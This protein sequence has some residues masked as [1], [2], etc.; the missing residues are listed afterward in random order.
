MNNEQDKYND[1]DT[2]ENFSNG[3]SK[4]RRRRAAKR[5]GITSA[6]HSSSKPNKWIKENTSPKT[7]AELNTAD[8][9]GSEIAE[10][11]NTVMEDNPQAVA[12]DAS[13]SNKK[14]NKGKKSPLKTFLTVL[15]SIIGV[16]VIVM[17]IFAISTYLNAD[18]DDDWSI[19][20]E[21]PIDKITEVF[22]PKLPDRTQFVIMCTDEDGTRTDTIMVG[23]YNS[24]TQGISLLSVPRDTI[25]SV[26]AAN[27]QTMREEFPEPGQRT[28]KINAV[29]HY[30]GNDLGPE[31]LVD[32][33]NS[34]LGTDIQYYVRINFDAFHYLIDSIGGIEFDVPQDMDYDDPTQDL[35]IHLKAGL[36]TLDGDKAEQL[37][38][39][40]KDNYGGGY[41][42]GDLGRIEMQQNFMKVLITKLASVD[43]IKSNPK[44]YITAFIK[45]VKTNAGVSDAVKYASALNKID[46]NKIDTYTLPGYIDY[47]AGISGYSPDKEQV[48]ELIYNICEKP[49]DEIVAEQ[50][51]ELTSEGEVTTAADSKSAE[52]KVLN[53]GYTGGKAGEV[54]GRLTADGYNVLEIGDYNDE[55]Q[56]S[57]RIFVNEKGLG[58]DLKD[59]F[60][61]AKVIEDSA[62]TGSY[63]IV[64]VIGTNE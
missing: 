27:Y 29:H 9:A 41:A 39:F 59:Y 49:I 45:Y 4:S 31:M 42:N 64:I 61:D 14:K 52:I 6:K 55:K 28:M 1:Y 26:S 50:Q 58:E 7:A 57:T 12:N 21:K 15:I 23:C 11:A 54:K 20:S 37:V 53:G 24:V 43:T 2:D 25:V 33:L 13:G 34:L 17:G 3:I 44:A 8:N 30:S 36:Q 38:R 46:T 10:A 47:V 48:D 51:G 22:S 32:E 40:R 35:A 19:K 62:L 56:A 16:Y 60:N 18:P 5:N 63:D